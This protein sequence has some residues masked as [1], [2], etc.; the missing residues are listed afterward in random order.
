VL[1]CLAS[2]DVE[3][4]K[5]E[6][7]KNTG[8]D[9][10]SECVSGHINVLKW[11]SLAAVIYITLPATPI[12]IAILILRKLT[13][14]RL[15]SM[16]SMS[17]QTRL[18]HS[19]LLKALVIQACLPIVF[20]VAVIFYLTGQLNIYHHP[21]FEYNIATIFG[22]LPVLSPLTS[23]YT[24]RP[25]R[26]WIDTTFLHSTKVSSLQRCNN[27]ETVC[28]SEVTGSLNRPASRCSQ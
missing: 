18:L 27:V 26:Q 19:Q 15:H 3:E 6:I 21:F 10:S 12:Y 9:T 22:L 28:R 16:T 2:D 8:Y 11:K 17:V 1:F 24:I 23:L 14:S 4:V 20:V 7:E 25:Y 13:I 5:R